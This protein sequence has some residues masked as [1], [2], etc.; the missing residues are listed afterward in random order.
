MVQKLLFRG[1]VAGLMAGLV[2]ALMQLIF[3]VPVLMDA[4]LYETGA[5]T[6]F[7]GAS[8]AAVHDH[9]HSAD[10]NLMRTVLTVLANIATF[11]GWGLITTVAMVFA[12]RAGHLPTLKTGLIWGISGFIAVHLM[13]AMGHAPELPGNAAADLSARQIWWVFAVLVSA[14]GLA[15]IGF[16]KG[17]LAIT[18]GMVVLLIPHLIGAPHPEGFT[19]PAPPELAGEF[20]ARAL[21][22]NA[23]A[24]A[25]LGAALGLFFEKDRA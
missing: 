16:G 3:V 4:E 12:A 14:I 23:F 19:G 8:S 25:T 10:G 18:G 9:T 22:A 1:L 13:P 21:A 6:H 7:G 11:I 17:V 20:A 15:I 2:A 5:L 24:W